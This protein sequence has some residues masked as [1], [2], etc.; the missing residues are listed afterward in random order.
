M[1]ALFA[2]GVIVLLILAG[3]ALEAAALSVLFHRTGRGIPPAILLPNLGAGACLL[4]AAGAALRGW[5]WGW[6]GA[7]LLVGGIMHLVD[8]RRR[9]R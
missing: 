1:T 6:I 3:V 5:W 4:A 7:L 8:L 9:W 2:S